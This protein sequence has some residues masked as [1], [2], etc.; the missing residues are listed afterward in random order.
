MLPLLL[1]FSAAAAGP[2]TC[3]FNSLKKPKIA[4]RPRPVSVA[5]SATSS[6]FRP[7]N[8]LFDTSNS[9]NAP[10]P[11]GFKALIRELILPQLAAWVPTFVQVNGPDTIDAIIEDPCEDGLSIPAIYGRGPIKADLLIFVT[12]ESNSSEG[13]LAQATFC[14]TDSQTRRPNVGFIRF[15]TYHMN[16][17]E[18]FF[19]LY[20][21]VSLHELF[22]VL[23]LH[24][25]LYDLYPN[26]P[27]P[28]SVYTLNNGVYSLKTAGVLAFARA[29]FNC[30]S[31]AGVALENEG[32][33]GS[34][35]AHFEKAL[36]GEEIMTAEV[37]AEMPVSGLILALMADSGWY[38]VSTSSAEQLWWGRGRGCSFT[39]SYCQNSFPEFCNATGLVQ[40]SSEFRAG[41]VCDQ[42]SFTKNCLINR[43]YT[44]YFCDQLYSPIFLLAAGYE[45]KGPTSRCFTV[46]GSSQG[47]GCF[48]SQCNGDGSVTFTARGSN[49]TCT[50]SGQRVTV[51]GY[52]VNCPNLLSFCQTRAANKCP[53]DCGGHGY[54]QNTGSCRCRYGYSDSGCTTDQ[55]CATQ[56]S[57]LCDKIFNPPKGDRL[58]FFLL[59]LFFVLYL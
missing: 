33:S 15:N 42:N 51:G 31:L 47:F 27:T 11:T 46:I 18:E 32:D 56:P 41:T 49:Y 53:N 38:Q 36:F 44:N 26:Y 30:S 40:C 6:A 3:G 50:S 28:N 37:S 24:P 22:H 55:T 16:L 20:I 23:V 7:I 10:V 25:S 1:G 45:T 5:S 54:C 52:Y 39:T 14:D 35:G 12:A 29:H 4:L 21:R 2:H 17:D 34:V 48:P 8:V 13:Y 57:V 59:T 19:D 58:S 9:D 43:Y